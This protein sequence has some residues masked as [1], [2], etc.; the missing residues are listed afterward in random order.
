[1]NTPQK[2]IPFWMSGSA[3]TIGMLLIEPALE[4]ESPLTLLG[5]LLTARQYIQVCPL[6]EVAYFFPGLRTVPVAAVAAAG[7]LFMAFGLWPVIARAQWTRIYRAGAILLTASFCILAVEFVVRGFWHIG[8]LQVRYGC[9]A[10]AGAGAALSVRNRGYLCAMALTAFCW[11]ISSA[12]FWAWLHGPLARLP[13]PYW[14]NL[15][16][17]TSGPPAL[18]PILV[19]AALL[20]AFSAFWKSSSDPLKLLLD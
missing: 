8:P 14:G 17:V 18:I 4:R 6:G 3:F 1:M 7:L 19:D 15:E 10:A 2:K 12:L 20:I 5:D 9:F 16:S 13:V 11:D